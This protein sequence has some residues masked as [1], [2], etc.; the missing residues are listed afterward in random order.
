MHGG[1]G[2]QLCVGVIFG[3]QRR[4]L[5]ERNEAGSSEHSDLPHCSTQHLAQ[6]KVATV[7][8]I[9]KDILGV[10]AF[11]NRLH[12]LTDQLIWQCFNGWNSACK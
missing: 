5:L 2:E 10:W 1:I 11:E 7:M 4:R 12:T 3:Q 6:W 9:L 8:T